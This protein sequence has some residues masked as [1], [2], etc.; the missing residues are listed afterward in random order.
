MVNESTVAAVTKIAFYDRT[1]RVDKINEEELKKRYAALHDIADERYGK[2]NY[3][4]VETYCDYG[5]SG[6][7]I[8]RPALAK[9]LEDSKNSE[10][11]AV[12]TFGTQY[13]SPFDTIL[14]CILTEL[15]ESNKLVITVIDID[16]TEQVVDILWCESS[17]NNQN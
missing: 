10:W 5:Y 16:G 1:T 3:Q 9:M 2:G 12:V 17:E 11:E 14:L 15:S 7:T 13:L 4:V 8:G 6:K